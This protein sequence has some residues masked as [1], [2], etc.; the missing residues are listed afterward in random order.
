[1]REISK[2]IEEAVNTTQGIKEVSSTSLEG[3]S[4]VRVQFNLGVDVA[5]ARSDIQ[6][7]VAR[8]RRQLPVNVEDPL[9]PD[10][11]S[12][13]AADHVDRRAERRAADP[14]AHRASPT[15]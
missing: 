9:D 4:I 13:R 5:E 7:K 2:P 8:I 6:G 3:T 10:V 1:M 12:Q 14:R 15:R 11:R